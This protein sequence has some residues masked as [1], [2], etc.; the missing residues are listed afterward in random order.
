MVEKSPIS[1][2]M[3]AA[4]PPICAAQPPDILKSTVERQ[5]FSLWYQGN[6]MMENQQLYDEKSAQI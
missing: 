1:A 6:I 2:P 5:F 3:C 4:E